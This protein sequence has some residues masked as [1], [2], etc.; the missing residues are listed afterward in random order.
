M[1]QS[2]KFYSFGLLLS[3]FVLPLAA[4]QT[5]WEPVADKVFLQEKSEILTTPSAVT[6]VAILS[7]R[8]YAVLDGKLQ[9]L[10]A[11]GLQ[12]VSE[13]PAGI[14]K[15]EVL[16]HSAWVMASSGF[17]RFAGNSWEKLS[18]DNFV[19][20]CLH[21]GKVHAATRDAIYVYEQGKLTDIE[22][23]GGYLSSDVT[24]LME[25]GT[26]LLADPVKLGPIT[27]IASYSGTL[28]VLRPGQLVHIRRYR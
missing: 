26:Q 19:D 21:L 14:S 24:M 10:K 28:H 27:S 3:V 20:V 9:E 25:D 5:L 1:I 12:P 2:L 6:Q 23:N 22:P 17:Y 7:G 16:D 13:G 15:L 18:D 8:S 4:Q 11:D